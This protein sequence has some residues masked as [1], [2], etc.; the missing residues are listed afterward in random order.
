M[1]FR[2]ELVTASDLAQFKADMQEAFNKGAEIGMGESGEVLPE[3]DINRSLEAEGA[4]AYKAVVD[5]RMLGGAVVR[6]DKKTKHNHLDFLYVNRCGFHIV[7]F[8]NSHHPDPNEPS[9]K[10]EESCEDEGMFR[11]E[12]YM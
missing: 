8:F 3:E 11:F 6:I 1:N 5:G 9:V 4:I 12:K 2:L 7:E 10:Q